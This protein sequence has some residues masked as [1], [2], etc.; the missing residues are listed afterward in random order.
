M[1][2]PLLVVVVLLLVFTGYQYIQCCLFYAIISVVV[3]FRITS[4]VL[5]PR[6]SFHLSILLPLMIKTCTVNN[7]E[8]HIHSVRNMFLRIK[9]TFRIK[10]PQQHYSFVQFDVYIILN[11]CKFVFRHL[12]YLYIQQLDTLN[13]TEKSWLDVLLKCGSLPY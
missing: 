7:I 11:V 8:T 9:R 4:V 10:Q 5:P 2:F 6:F 1:L 12:G 13:C 3:T